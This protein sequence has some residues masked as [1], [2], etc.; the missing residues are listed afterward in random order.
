MSTAAVVQDSK[1]R[2]LYVLAG[3][4]E[5]GSSPDKKVRFMLLVLVLTVDRVHAMLPRVITGKPLLRILC[6]GTL[7]EF[8][9]LVRFSLSSPTDRGLKL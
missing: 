9:H 2:D 5:N 6:E 4:K 1:S 8:P 3:V 7:R